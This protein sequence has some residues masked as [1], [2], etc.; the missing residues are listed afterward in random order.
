MFIKVD[1]DSSISHHHL[2]RPHSYP[3]HTLYVFHGL[4]TEQYCLCTRSA[5][6]KST[7][8][9]TQSTAGWPI[10]RSSLR[11]QLFKPS[12]AISNWSCQ[13]GLRTAQ[14]SRLLPVQLRVQRR[15]FRKLSLISQVSELRWWISPY[16]YAI[17]F[18]VLYDIVIAA[19]LQLQQ[20]F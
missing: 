16:N 17:L 6:F 20:V 1:P 11:G 10:S 5:F 4:I 3:H 12:T 18:P 15:S 2:I 9:R 14:S 19:F 7:G 13:L 8:F